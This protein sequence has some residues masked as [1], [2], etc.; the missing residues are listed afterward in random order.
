MSE[1]T[2][3]QLASTVGIPVE[4]LLTQ[5]SEAGISASGADSTL[6]EQEKAATPEL[7][8]AQSRQGRGRGRRRDPVRS[9]SS[10][11]RSASCASPRC[12]ARPRQRRRGARLPADPPARAKTVSVEVRRKR[13]YVKRPDERGERGRGARRHR[14]PVH[15]APPPVPSP[16]SA[17]RRP[18]P[19]RRAERRPRSRLRRGRRRSELEAM[20]AEQE[21]RR[22]ADQEDQERQAREEEERRREAEEARA[23]RRGR[24]PP[25][26][27]GGGAPAAPSAEAAAAAPRATPGRPQRRSRW[28][29]EEDRSRRPV[30]A[31]AARRA[32][33]AKKPQS[34]RSRS[35]AEAPRRNVRSRRPARKDSAAVPAMHRG[36]PRAE[37]EEVEGAAG[38]RAAASQR[39]KR[40]GKPQLQDKHVFQRP[41]APVVREVE[42]PESISVG[43]LASR[44]SVK[45]AR[46]HQ[47]TVQAGHDG[48]HQPDP[49]SRYRHPAGRGDGPQGGRRRCARPPRTP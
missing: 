16:A 49:G 5:L 33:A 4:R 21:A 26:G 20:R 35:R 6:T 46:C 44:M 45:V 24:G 10:A 27:R 34:R 31:A 15:E 30:H 41:T 9:P 39:K 11:S 29:T 23:V 7:S 1:V 40:I 36:C 8:A 19:R 38:R 25:P 12:P 47:G 3:K 37:Y 17:R 42:I 43:E 22:L 48:H 2:V 18:G 14:R 13:T 32:K 28:S